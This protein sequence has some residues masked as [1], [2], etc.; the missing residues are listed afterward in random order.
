MNSDQVRELESRLLELS[1]E[2]LLELMKSTLQTN[3]KARRVGLSQLEL[4]REVCLNFFRQNHYEPDR[5]RLNRDIEIVLNKVKRILNAHDEYFVSGLGKMLKED[6]VPMET[7]LWKLRQPEL[8]LKQE[9][10]REEQPEEKAREEEEQT[11][12][13]PF[14]PAEYPGLAEL[15]EQLPPTLTEK[16]AQSIKLNVDE[17]ILYSAVE[18]GFFHNEM[19]EAFVKNYAH[20][21]IDSK[22]SALKSERKTDNDSRIR[23]YTN[24]FVS[25]LKR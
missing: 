10:Q 21:L 11:F 5:K 12:K 23:Q 4:T 7:T 20:S 8:E 9:P 3:E 19:E 15:L 2:E 16:A 25:L 6:S 17:M 24:K 1:R 14:R 22:V 13:F 18:H